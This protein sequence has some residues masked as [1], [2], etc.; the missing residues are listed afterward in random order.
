MAK[1]EKS[2]EE[3][4]TEVTAKKEDIEKAETEVQNVRKDSSDIEKQLNSVEKNL[5]QQEQIESR[6]AIK[7][8]SL[9][10]DC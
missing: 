5:M 6:R 3:Y 1:I 9:L 2:L 10:H 7:R 4:K 8:H